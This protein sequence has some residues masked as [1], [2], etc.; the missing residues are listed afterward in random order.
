M[1]ELL[2]CVVRISLA[3][4]KKV[5][6]PLEEFR[7]VFVYIADISAHAQEIKNKIHQVTFECFCVLL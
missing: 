2:L 3:W 1:G 5:E 6:S 7:K 4:K